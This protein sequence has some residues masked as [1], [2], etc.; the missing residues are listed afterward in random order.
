LATYSASTLAKLSASKESAQHFDLSQRGDAPN[1]NISKGWQYLPIV[2]A[3]PQQI[4]KMKTNPKI[5]E[6]LR[7]IH[8]PTQENLSPRHC[9]QRGQITCEAR[10]ANY[11]AQQQKIVDDEYY[12]IVVLPQ[13]KAQEEEYARQQEAYNKKVEEEREVYATLK[14]R[15]AE[16]E[17]KPTPKPTPKASTTSYLPL[18]VV[19]IVIVVILLILRRRA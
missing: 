5:A 9:G 3:N 14:M 18:A 11:K 7:E 10:L 15:V 17:K 19:G 1:P 8:A 13:I 6:A 2:D 16:L 12:K 4:E